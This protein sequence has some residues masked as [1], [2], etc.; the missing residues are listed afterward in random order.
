MVDGEDMPVRGVQLD[1]ELKRLIGRDRR[2][3]WVLVT[4]KVAAILSAIVIA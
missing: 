2:M 1:A 4:T 3:K